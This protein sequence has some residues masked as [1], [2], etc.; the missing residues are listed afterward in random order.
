MKRFIPILLLL[1]VIDFTKSEE[2]VFQVQD[3]PQ[4]KIDPLD[5]QTIWVDPVTKSG[6]CVHACLVTLFR[7]QDRD[8]W[9]VYWRANYSGGMRNAWLVKY[10]EENEIPY[11][12]T[13]QEKDV[14]FLERTMSEQLGTLATTSIDNP[15]DHMLLLVHL[16]PCEAAII[17]TRTSNAIVWVDR[18]KFLETWFRSDS[19]A[20]TVL[21]KTPR[22]K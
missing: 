10:L 3:R 16:G 4:I 14:K 8:D 15:A 2:I 22:N 19:W 12:N 20:T 13:F 7:Y 5:L 11:R 18:E 1:F 9:A 21:L 6:S 17:D